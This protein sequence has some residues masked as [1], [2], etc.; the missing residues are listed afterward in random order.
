MVWLSLDDCSGAI[1]LLLLFEAR[2]EG[3]DGSGGL[4]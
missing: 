3:G 2:A 1:A 4:P